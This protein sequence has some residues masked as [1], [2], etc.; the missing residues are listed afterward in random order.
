MP[1]SRGE[2]PRDSTVK[3]RPCARETGCGGGKVWVARVFAGWGRS[4]SSRGRSKAGVK[5]GRKHSKSG[6][7]RSQSSPQ[8]FG[9]GVA[10]SLRD[11]WARSWRKPDWKSSGRHAA[12]A[13][14][15]H[16]L[17]AILRHRLRS[18]YP[19]SSAGGL[20]DEAGDGGE[21]GED[22]AEDGG[23]GGVG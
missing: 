9:D 13:Q 1:K 16:R 15:V 23:F 22:V 4:K 2:S 19:Q 7:R 14:P 20:A 10:V 3:T 8:Q 17:R 21:E 5:P 18:G 12:I 11:K 6:E